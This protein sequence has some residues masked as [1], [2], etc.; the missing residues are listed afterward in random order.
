MQK[1]WF[2]VV[3]AVAITAVAVPSLLARQQS[4]IPR[5]QYL[6]VTPYR[7]NHQEGR[8]IT[9]RPAYQACVAE[10][11]WACRRFEA[12]STGSFNQRD[13]PRPA[14]R[15]MLV[16]LGNEGWELAS[17]LDDSPNDDELT[18]LFKR[19]Q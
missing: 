12:P 18:Y 16:T 7:S 4:A 3:I 13:E 15:A 17:T 6:V 14:L 11:E 1:L 19:Q 5:F 9:Y 10:A 8:S 2:A